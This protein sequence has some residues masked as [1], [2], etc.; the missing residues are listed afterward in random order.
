MI[1][2]LYEPYALG[3]NVP[4]VSNSQLKNK[5]DIRG[6]I[7]EKQGMYVPVVFT[8]VPSSYSH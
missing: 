1:I 4:S 7:Y 8:G 5:I 2:V 3:S 6:K